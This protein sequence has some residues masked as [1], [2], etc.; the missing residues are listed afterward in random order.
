MVLTDLI[1]TTLSPILIYIILL[2]GSI[3]DTLIGINI[4]IHGELFFLSGAYLSSIGYLNIFLVYISLI[5]GALIGDNISYYLGTKLQFKYKEKSKV[6]NQKNHNK[7]KQLFQKHGTKAIFFSKFLGPVAWITPFVAGNLKYKYKT[8]ALYNFLGILGGIGQFMIVGY[9]G[10]IIL[11]LY[12]YTFFTIIIFI[13]LLILGY[14]LFIKNKEIKKR[15][16]II[17]IISLIIIIYFLAISSFYFIFYPKTINYDN[18]DYENNFTALNQTLTQFNQNHTYAD[19]VLKNYE[20][21]INIIIITN[22]STNEIFNQINWT[23]NLLFSKD[24]I[25]IKKFVKLLTSKDENLP[26]SDFYLKNKTPDFAY[27]NKDGNFIHRNHI[28]LWNIGTLN[29]THQI[30]YGSISEDDGLSIRLYQLIP[31]ITHDIEILIDE[32]REKLKSK[33]EKNIESV[34]FEYIQLNENTLNKADTT[35]KD[36]VTDGKTLVIYY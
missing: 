6:F 27:Q 13:I 14:R 29:Q 35:N 23:E 10:S 17:K 4:F 36:Y 12:I 26:I 5:I 32:S 11:N 24:E 28:R 16:I 25:G 34:R 33:I 22:K 15:Y 9:F 7:V 21:P 20:H 3:G 18:Q 1:N 31:T 30:F 2:L 8:F 19:K